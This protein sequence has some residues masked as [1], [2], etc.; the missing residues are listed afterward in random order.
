MAAVITVAL[1]MMTLPPA[2]STGLWQFSAVFPNRSEENH[3][4]LLPLRYVPLDALTLCM[5]LAS[6]DLFRD[7]ILF[8]YAGQDSPNELHVWLEVD[9]RYAFY[10]RDHVA[11][12]KLPPLD[13]IL[14]HLC[15]TWESDTGAT[16]VWMD[17]QPSRKK[18]MARG[19]AVR[20]PVVVMIGQDQ[21]VVGGSFEAGQSFVGVQRDVHLWD[22]VLP[23]SKIKSVAQGTARLGGNIINWD[24][25][26]FKAE[27]NVQFEPVLDSL[28]L[29]SEQS[30]HSYM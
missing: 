29:A 20:I 14:R 16:T 26:N 28:E 4:T 12:F 17:G 18:V 7:V 5:R 25:G 24:R 27:G 8:S 1:L 2:M 10:I 13:D 3:V 9:G 30:C 11:Y 19:Q 23:A 15:F 6:E 21:D 22:Y